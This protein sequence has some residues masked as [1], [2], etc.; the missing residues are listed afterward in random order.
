VARLCP[1][2]DYVQY[3]VMHRHANG[4]L[5]LLVRPQDARS[6]RRQDPTVV[7]VD[8]SANIQ[9]LNSWCR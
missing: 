8:T 3:S 5:L 6:G 9:V 4:A 1:G 7:K 2:S